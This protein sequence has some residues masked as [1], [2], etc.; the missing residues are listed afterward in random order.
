MFLT[1]NYEQT[2]LENSQGDYISISVES[3]MLD[4]QAGKPSKHTLELN[5]I[6]R[7]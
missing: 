4:Q 5:K 3:F 7:R 2:I 1:K 6:Q